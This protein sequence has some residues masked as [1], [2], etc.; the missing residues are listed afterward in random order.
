[1]MLEM[2]LIVM[3]EER[4]REAVVCVSPAPTRISGKADTGIRPLVRLPSYSFK[5]QGG[6]L[7]RHLIWGPIDRSSRTFALVLDQVT[8]HDLFQQKVT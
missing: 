1:M 4:R 8:G 3:C 2:V 7:N 5:V 6:Q